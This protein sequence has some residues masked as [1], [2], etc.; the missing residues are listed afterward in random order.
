[1]STSKRQDI[2]AILTARVAGIKRTSGYQTDAGRALYTQEVPELG[3][4]DPDAAI[5]ILVAEDD[6]TVQGMQVGIS[7]PF[8]F[9]AIAKA[10]SAGA[11][12]AIEAM[13]ADIKKAVESG[14]RHLTAEDSTGKTAKY[15]PSGMRRGT[16]R[17]I[18]RESG[19]QTVG[20]AIRYVVPYAEVWGTP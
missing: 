3:Q 14:D 7:L 15:S 8:D 2:I 13:L 18:P 12:V 11:W 6:P 4:D 10:G 19:S 9:C 5:A 1:M 17:T 20:V 16:T